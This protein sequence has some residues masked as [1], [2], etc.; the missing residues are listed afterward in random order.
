MHSVPDL[1]SRLSACDPVLVAAINSLAS[2]IQQSA[3]TTST[4]PR[5]F[6][7]GGIVRDLILGRTIVDADME[8]YGVPGDELYALLQRLFP[9][10]VHDVGRAFCVYKVTLTGGHEL[11]VSLPRRES[12]TG[13]GHKGFTVIGD[14]T[15]SITDAARRRDFTVNALLADP[16]TGE[17]MDP[18][19]GLQDLE[20]GILRAVDAATFV[21]DPLRVYRALQFAARLDLIPDTTTRELLREMVL[22]G[23]LDELPKERV[24]EEIRKLLLSAE[25]PSIG[26]ALARELGI[27]KRDYPELH[28]L[29]DTQQEPEWHPEGDVWIHTLMV[30][31]EAARIIR[32]PDSA[33]NE[34]DV[35]LGALCHDLGK[36][37]VTEHVEGRIRSREHEAHGEGPTRS[38]LA[39]WTF[40][41][42]VEEAVVLIVKDHLKPGML[43]REL[44]TGRMNEEQYLNAVRRLLKRVYPVD[45]RTFLAACESDWRGRGLPEVKEDYYP[46]GERFAQAVRDGHL[47][48]APANS[49]LRGDDLIAL[50]V[51]PGP[52]MGRIIRETE[53]ARDRGEVKTKE[54]ALRLAK[55]LQK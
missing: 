52:E 13:Q 27:I 24:T 47:D 3:N 11:D 38:L 26:F 45:W 41:S 1:Q 46:A 28:A 7:V 55:Q 30:I 18:H 5:A 44:E 19:N 43:L 37:G 4:P 53:E 17:V 22:R 14:P 54:E 33:V 40:G 23:D 15:M 49:L 16:L 6:L 31:D 35:M 29:I 51:Q 21:E 36:P 9:S 2:S 50:G 39:R 32:R 42:D 34:L 8:V 10:N 20:R 12:K 48:A 25:R